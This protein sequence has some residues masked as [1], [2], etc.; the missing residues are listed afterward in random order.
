MS[1]SATVAIIAR[2]EAVRIAAA[3][4]SVTEQSRSVHVL[5]VDDHS[6]DDTTDVAAAGGAIVV[7]NQGRGIVDARNTAIEAADTDVIVWLDADDRLMPGS[8]DAVLAAFA[9]PGVE[10][11]AGSP[12]FVDEFGDVLAHQPAPPDTIRSRITAMAFNPF[13]QSAVAVRRSTLLAAGGYRHGAETDAA[14]DYD[15]WARLLAADVAMVGLPQPTVT[16]TIRPGSETGRSATPQSRRAAAIRSELRCTARNDLDSI[17][18]LRRLGRELP[19][20]WS[21]PTQLDTYSLALLRLGAQQARSGEVARG[22]RLVVGCLAIGP[23]RTTWSAG[24]AAAG[25]RRR[26]RARGWRR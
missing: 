25:I 10:L 6:S 1:P 26:R 21:R 5:V 4:R 23:V 14:E 17:A 3:I 2:D 9:D 12:R 7:T 11:V 13:S 20:S 24:R 19:F 18:T 15:L 22:A 16:M 8:L